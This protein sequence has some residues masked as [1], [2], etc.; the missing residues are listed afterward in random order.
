MAKSVQEEL[1][2]IE[3]GIANLQDQEQEEIPIVSIACHARNSLIL[4]VES[5]K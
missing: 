3:E 1:V 5:K 4:N 2:E